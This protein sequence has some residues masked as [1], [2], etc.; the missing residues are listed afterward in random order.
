MISGTCQCCA[1][2][3]TPEVAARSLEKLAELSRQSAATG[4][5]VWKVCAVVTQPAQLQ[6]R[7]SKRVLA[8]SPVAKAAEALGIPVLSPEKAKDE[9]FLL[10]LEAM[11]PDLCIT[12]AYGQW[13]PKRFLACPRLGTLNIHPSLLP[14]WRG[15]S[16]VQRSLEAGDEE[17]GVSVLWTVAKMDAGPIAAQ[18]VRPLA[19]DE[20]APDLLA[21]LFDAG[22]QSLASVLPKVFSGECTMETSQVQDETLVVAA[23]KISVDEAEVCFQRDSAAT[24]HHRVRGFA[25]WPGV[26]SMFCVGEGEPERFKLITTRIADPSELPT[27]YSGGREVALVGK[28][29]GRLLVPCTDGTVLEVLELQAPGKKVM[30]ALAFANGLRGEGLRWQPRSSSDSQ[31]LEP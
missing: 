21:E 8:P 3:G 6:G 12:A 14:R 23:D 2:S 17:T 27:G 13:L 5:E 22:T 26:W 20:K 31:S 16:P 25:G 24:V 29:G 18:L 10:K 9:A 7:G 11:Q 30:G 28:A 15:A 1:C 19:G 4:T